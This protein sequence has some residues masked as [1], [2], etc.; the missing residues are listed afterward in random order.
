MAGAGIRAHRTAAGNNAAGCPGL[1]DRRARVAN[2]G[3]GAEVGAVEGAAGGG[4]GRNVL[5]DFA[6]VGRRVRHGRP[7]EEQ[8][9]S[10]DRGENQ[11]F[12]GIDTFVCQAEVVPPVLK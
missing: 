8:P 5:G 10:D 1:R 2:T 9:D 11:C 3:L 7:G 12:H 4:R 6:V